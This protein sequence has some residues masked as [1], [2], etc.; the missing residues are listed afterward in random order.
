M[1]AAILAA[2]ATGLTAAYGVVA[3]PAAEAAATAQPV[4]ATAEAAP[5]V[6]MSGLLHHL[7]FFIEIQHN[8]VLKIFKYNLLQRKEEHS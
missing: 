3:V 6:Y 7:L 1:K 5:I 2:T 4:V 8:C